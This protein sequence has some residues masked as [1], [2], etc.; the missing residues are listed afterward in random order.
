MGLNSL[1]NGGRGVTRGNP[2]LDHIN[3]MYFMLFN[4]A[5]NLFIEIL[6]KLQAFSVF[7]IVIWKILHKILHIE[8]FFEWTPS[9]HSKVRV[10]GDCSQ[11]CVP[12]FL[13]NC[14]GMPLLQF[15]PHQKIDPL[16]PSCYSPLSLPN[17]CPDQIL[18]KQLSSITFKEILRNIFACKLHFQKNNHD[19]MEKVNQD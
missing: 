11:P 1:D 16:F 8:A 15:F 17:P 7:I 5:W 10:G 19:L 18:E 14:G 9:I 6:S 3:K 2:R 12:E 13:T 4:M